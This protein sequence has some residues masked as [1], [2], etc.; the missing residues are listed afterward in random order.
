[1]AI[2][3]KDYIFSFDM[4]NRTETPRIE[5]VQGDNKSC[6][7]NINL[8]ADGSSIDLTS[9]SV[10]SFF[11]TSD[12]EYHENPV[13]IV[14]VINGSIKIVI[15]SEILSIVGEVKGVIRLMDENGY[16]LTSPE[17]KFKV[18]QSID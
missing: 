9:I 12:N 2:P 6:V 1:M 15:S 11:K 5:Y 13:T 8:T 10:R 4:K 17:F 16:K 14:D 18:R 3:D 7:L